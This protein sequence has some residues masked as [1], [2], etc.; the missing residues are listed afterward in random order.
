M[1]GMAL[2][3]RLD[4]RTVAL[5]SEQ[6]GSPYWKSLTAVL[7]LVSGLCDSSV[8]KLTREDDGSVSVEG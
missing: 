1:V 2:T 8:S 3:V 7:A 6:P 4:G 5:H